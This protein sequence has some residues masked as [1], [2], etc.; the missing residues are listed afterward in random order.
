MEG[1]AQLSGTVRGG[2][3]GLSPVGTPK[4]APNGPKPGVPAKP[5]PV[6]SAAPMLPSSRTKLSSM[7]R[8]VVLSLLYKHGL[9]IDKESG[10]KRSAAVMSKADRAATP[11]VPVTKEGRLLLKL[12]SMAGTEGV[13]SMVKRGDSAKTA[14][15][16]IAAV[17]KLKRAFKRLG[18]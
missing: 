16:K 6:P 2:P 1:T 5:A 17:I 8:A 18:C 7:K 10:A 4:I 9:G 15:R 3:I 11:Y 13:T 14:A 12:A